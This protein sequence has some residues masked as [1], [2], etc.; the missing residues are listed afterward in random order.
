MPPCL[1][2]LRRKS[3]KRFKIVSVVKKKRIDLPNQEMIDSSESENEGYEAHSK[4]KGKIELESAL[5]WNWG[6]NRTLKG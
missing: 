5:S 1:Q 6:L 4:G 3:C 2:C